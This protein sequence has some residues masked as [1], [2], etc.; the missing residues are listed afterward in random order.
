MTDSEL[1]L[2]LE[3]QVSL[4]QEL[5]DLSQRQLAESDQVGIDGVLSQK[6]VCFKELQQVD[7]MLILWHKQ[8]ERDFSKE[9]EFIYANV[10]V[11]LEKLLLSEKEYEKLVGREKNAVSLQISQ[12]SSQMQYREGPKK[13]RS[14]IKN[15]TT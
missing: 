4:L 1:K 3:K 2:L 15:M 10:E 14:Q 11:L 12:L 13:N 8:Y 6:D 5:L 7:S 9:E